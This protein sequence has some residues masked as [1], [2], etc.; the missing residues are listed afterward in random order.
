MHVKFDQEYHFQI[1]HNKV[2]VLE[3]GDPQAEPILCLH[4]WLDN[5][6]TFHYLAPFLADKYRL[7]IGR[8]HV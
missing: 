4:G 8:A 2:A 7:K 5:A 3:W 6:A 1:H